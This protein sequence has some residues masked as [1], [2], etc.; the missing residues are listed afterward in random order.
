[1]RDVWIGGHPRA[2]WSMVECHGALTRLTIAR[3]IFLLSLRQEIVTWHSLRISP[4]VEAVLWI[5]RRYNFA[6]RLISIVSLVSAVSVGIHLIALRE[7]DGS[8]RLREARGESRALTLLNLSFPK[9]IFVQTRLLILVLVY[10]SLG[11]S[12][13][14]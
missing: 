11:D 13:R 2:S 12:R 14:F 7:V 9:A 4:S 10:V 3:T 8:V 1:M 6:Y 5:P